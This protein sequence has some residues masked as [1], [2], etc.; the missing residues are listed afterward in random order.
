MYIGGKLDSDTYFR[1]EKNGVIL[2]RLI[3]NKYIFLKDIFVKNK[4][5]LR[6]INISE[7]K[8]GTDVD[9]VYPVCVCCLAENKCNL[10]C[11]YCFGHDKMYDRIQ[12]GSIEELYAPLVHIHP[13]QVSLGGGEPTLNPQIGEIIN[14]LSA[15][16]IAVV[17]DTN[18][19]TQSLK[20]LVP[21]LKS[22]GSLV[23]ISMDSLNDE[24]INNIRPL[25]KSVRDGNNAACCKSLSNEIQK[26]IDYLLENGVFVSVHTVLTQRNKD[27]ILELTEFILKRGIKRWHMDGAK[28]SEKCKDFYEDI[29]ISKETILEIMQS[30][31]KYREQIHITF[32]YEEDSA[33]NVRLFFDVNGVF[34]TDSVYQGLNYLD[35]KADLEDIYG[36]L[37][38][39][40]HIE[41][42]LGN[43]YI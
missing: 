2:Y 12:T 11:I 34:L 18:G 24:I 28:C 30:L 20:D 25:K 42:Y 16:E 19:T 17:L 32:S 3:E 33:P 10:D 31:E 35:K 15:H 37:D 38:K 26:N 39:K 27:S 40:R 29:K 1:Q 13:I 8:T 23:R 36:I 7:K 22:T 43:F 41:R 4:D 5:E 21:I 9:L 6:K 14:F